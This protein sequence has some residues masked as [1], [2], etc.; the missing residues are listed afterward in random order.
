MFMKSFYLDTQ[1]VNVF[2]NTIMELFLRHVIE[3]CLFQTFG[4]YKNKEHVK[5]LQ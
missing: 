1:L 2:T 5:S 3:F 4:P